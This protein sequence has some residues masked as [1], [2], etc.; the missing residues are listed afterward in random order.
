MIQRWQTSVQCTE[1]FSL[2]LWIS[3]S[4]V[5]MS[6]WEKANHVDQLVWNGNRRIVLFSLYFHSCLFCCLFWQG[7]YLY[8][9]VLAFPSLS[10]QGKKCWLNKR[11]TLFKWWQSYQYECTGLLGTGRTDTAEL[12]W[13]CF[14][15]CYVFAPLK[16]RVTWT[17]LVLNLLSF[18]DIEN[19]QKTPNKLFMV[20]GSFLRLE[21]NFELD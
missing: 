2:C 12:R 17:H 19:M 4:L 1:Y 9:L 5:T 13:N 8:P 10:N 20:V 14:E 16:A 18:L 21:L 11:S 3:G 6:L 7:K 15:F